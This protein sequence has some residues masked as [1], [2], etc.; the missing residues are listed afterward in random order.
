[1]TPQELAQKL[2]GVPG[3]GCVAVTGAGIQAIS[4]LFSQ[5]GTSRT[6]LE[7]LVPYARKALDEFVGIQAGQHVSAEEAGLIA[8]AALKRARHLADAP[9]SAIPAA[10]ESPE[11]E[12]LFGI[13][14][15]AA[16]ATD[17]VRRGEDRAH[18][19]W[20]DG[21]RSG[22]TSIW[23]DK[24]ARTREEE[25]TIVSAIVLNSI[26]EVV[27]VEERLAIEML[28]TERLDELD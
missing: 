13:G 22:G 10:G 11:P 3:R 23:F 27:G 4:D 20:T 14:C 21:T 28:S 7:A 8:E 19:A 18:V 12:L 24:S 1:M 15:T 6:I 5:P 2:H 9:D 16:V 25:D 26:A 17:R